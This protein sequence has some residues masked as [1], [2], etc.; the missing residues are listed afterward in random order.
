MS[1]ISLSSAVD[2]LRSLVAGDPTLRDTLRDEGVEAALA[3]AGRDVE[4]APDP[5]RQRRLR[6]ALDAAW[7]A[8]SRLS[9]A[10]HGTLRAL[11]VGDR[12]AGAGPA[13]E[14]PTASGV[15]VGGAPA[16]GSPTIEARPREAPRL[17]VVAP[18]PSELTASIGA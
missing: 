15:R 17:S 18:T 13:L 2:A 3:R 11:V 5:E 1:R 9:V 16:R 10:H 6:S 12:A 4:A 14:A 7:R 8:V